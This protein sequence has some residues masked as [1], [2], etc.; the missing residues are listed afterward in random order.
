M[1][2]NVSIVTSQIVLCTATDCVVCMCYVQWWVLGWLPPRSSWVFGNPPK[3]GGTINQLVKLSLNCCRW[4]AYPI[5]VCWLSAILQIF[6]FSF[7]KKLK[8]K[9]SKSCAYHIQPI[10]SACNNDDKPRDHQQ[11]MFQ[12]LAEFV[13]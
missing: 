8:C 9:S 5:W 2:Y 13:S 10:V 12:F 4:K 1:S 3:Q 11:L 6:I 7:W